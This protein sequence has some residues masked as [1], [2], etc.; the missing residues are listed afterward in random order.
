MDTTVSVTSRAPSYTRLAQQDRRSSRRPNARAGRA[1]TFTD[2][3]T[4]GT[5]A[6]QGLF[7]PWRH[8]RMQQG[9]V[10]GDPQPL[11]A[12]S[13]GTATL[14]DSTICLPGITPGVPHTASHDGQP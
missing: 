9:V 2:Q 12:F 10:H 5:L 7:H 14:L 11:R 13:C 6:P 1:G 8:T 4:H 3:S